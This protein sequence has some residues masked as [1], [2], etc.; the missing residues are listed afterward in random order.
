MGTASERHNVTE[1]VAKCPEQSPSGRDV[2]LSR[3]RQV[4]AC[5]PSRLCSLTELYVHGFHT[6]RAQGW[7]RST[8]EFWSREE[9]FCAGLFVVAESSV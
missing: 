9:G 8:D 6:A 7:A 3:A 2:L 5:E 4:T 1:S